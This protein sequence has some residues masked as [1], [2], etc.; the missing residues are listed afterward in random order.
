MK[1]EDA[2]FYFEKITSISDD[3]FIVVD[4]NG[5]IL[6]INDI[7][8]KFLGKKNKLYVVGKHITEIIPNTKMLDIMN[9]KYHEEVGVHHYLD[10]KAKEK[11]VLVSRS[12]VENDIGEVIGGVAQVKFR[13][14]SLDV[15]K[16]LMEEYEQF[17]FYKSEYEKNRP[18]C[19]FDH[20]IGSS[21]EFLEMKKQGLKVCKTNFSILLT[22]ETGT[23]KEVFAKA[24]HNSSDRAKKPM[25]SINCAA[26]PKELL[27][28]EL[29]G[30]VE[31]AFTGAKKGG[32]KGKFLIA[33]NGTLFL[34]EIGDMDILMQSKLLRVLQEKEIEPIGSNETIPIDVRII[35][36]TRRNIHQMV[37]EGTFRED[38]YY[39]LNVI[40]IEMLPLRQRKED[41]LELAEYFLEKLNSEYRTKKKLS[42]IVKKHFYDYNWPGN[43]RELDNVIKSA[44][45]ASEGE[46]ILEEDLPFKIS[47]KTHNEKII[48]NKNK[49]LH[50]LVENYEKNIIIKFL[51]VNNWNYQQTAKEMEIH[52]SLLYKKINK[53]GITRPKN[54]DISIKDFIS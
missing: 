11:T 40:N 37:Q 44:Y 35:A 33:N 31:G 5:Y 18:R 21:K 26:I 38:L 23:G 1:K 12:Y 8:C 52:R 28:S 32:K 50:F 41:I 24:I 39:R 13:L 29:F 42:N 16:K 47:N 22:G 14:Q 10:N 45:A 43:V 4:R 6:D 2:Y 27:E 19:Y 15:A 53:Y 34:D 48:L 49:N 25:V 3:G 9:L 46:Y 30:Y 7:Y 20:L 17:E 36:A 51:E 54:L